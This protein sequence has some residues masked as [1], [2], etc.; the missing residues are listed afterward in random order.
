MA[1]ARARLIVHWPQIDDI[2]NSC[3]NC[4]ECQNDRPNNPKQTL[5][6]L[7]VL[8]YAFEFTSADYFIQ[9]VTYFLC[10]LISIRVLILLC[11][12]WANGL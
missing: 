1:Q 8:S 6:Y 4:Q 11:V 7:P 10:S 3:R 9:T 12:L 5:K 2:E